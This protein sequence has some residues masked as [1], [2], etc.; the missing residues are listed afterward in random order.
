MQYA[1]GF[2]IAQ[3]YRDMRMEIERCS[4]LLDCSN[5]DHGT[6]QQSVSPRELMLMVKQAE[7]Q[8]S[9]L[10]SLIHAKPG[11]GVASLRNAHLHLSYENA[12]LIASYLASERPFMKSFDV[13]LRQVVLTTLVLTLD[14]FVMRISFQIIAVLA[15]TSVAI[16]T[17]AVKCLT[18]VVEADP[19]LLSRVSQPLV[20]LHLVSSMET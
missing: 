1:K 3:W 19:T 18:A 16:R 12:C 11:S 20:D 14:R 10:L 13:Y 2:Y 7:R 8:K 6:S 15:E 17:K 9:F 4:K 5:A